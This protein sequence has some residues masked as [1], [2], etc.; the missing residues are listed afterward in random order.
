[1]AHTVLAVLDLI[2]HTVQISLPAWWT[3]STL[4]LVPLTGGPACF[5]GKIPDLITHTVLIS[6]P[7]HMQC[8]QSLT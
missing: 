6:L 2:A 7:G 3:G 4:T 8:W 5:G 1:M